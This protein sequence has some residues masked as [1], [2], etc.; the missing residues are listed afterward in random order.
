[1]PGQIKRPAAEKKPAGL[2]ICVIPVYMSVSSS[3]YIVVPFFEIVSF[4]SL[5]RDN[6]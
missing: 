3:F 2:F 4:D 5:F 6:L 1:M